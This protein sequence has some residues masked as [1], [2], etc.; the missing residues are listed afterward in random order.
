M[1]D[2]D[3][4]PCPPDIDAEN[5]PEAAVEFL[6]SQ[7]PAEF[8]N[9][10]CWFQW[11]SSAGVW[12]WN[13][14]RAHIFFWL[15]RPIPDDELKDWAKRIDAK[16]DKSLFNGVQ[17]HYTAAP[18]FDD[19]VADPVS[20]RSG[21]LKKEEQSVALRLLP[22][23]EKKSHSGTR[24]PFAEAVGFENWLVRIGDHEGGEGFHAPIRGAIASYVSTHG[25]VADRDALKEHL[26]D[27]ISNAENHHRDEATIEHYMSDAYLDASIDGAIEKFG[28][29]KRGRLVEGIPPHFKTS[30][31]TPKIAEALI[32]KHIWSWWDREVNWGDYLPSE[33]TPADQR[34]AIK[35]W[36]LGILPVPYVNSLLLIGSAGIGKST[37]AIQA[38]KTMRQ[39]D[40][41][42]VIWYLTPT[43]ELAEELAAKFGDYARVIRG[44]THRDK[45]G[46]TLCKKPEAV[47]AVAGHV[48]SI[49]KAVCKS[50]TSRCEHYDYC[51]YYAQFQAR[52][53]VYF[54][55]YEYAFQ[56]R[57]P[58]IFPPDMLIID[59]N[60]LPNFVKQLPPFTPEEFEKSA[61]RWAPL[62][63]FIVAA[64]EDHKS[65]KITLKEDRPFWTERRLRRLSKRLEDSQALQINPDMRMT[66]IKRVIG[67]NKRL[68][69]ANVVFRCL[70]A[71]M[72]LARDDVYSLVLQKDKPVKIVIDG[73]EY[74][75]FE[76][77][78]FVQYRRQ[79]KIKKETPTLIL[80][81]TGNF[82]LL[83]PNFSRIATERVE[84]TRNAIVVQTYGFRASKT[85]LVGEGEDAVRHQ[86][87]IEHFLNSF[88]KSVRGL[89]V[90]H[91][92]V[93]SDIGLPAGWQSVHLGNLRG[94]DKY[95]ECNVIV[96]VARLQPTTDAIERMAMGLFSDVDQ[97]LTNLGQEYSEEER[98]Y[99]M[100]DGSKYGVRVRCHP[101]PFVQALLEQSREMEIVQAIDRIRLRWTDEKKL[102]IVLTEIPVDV[103]VDVLIPYKDLIA[104]GSRIDRAA[105]E[106][107]GVLPTAPKF[108][109]ARFPGLWSTPK[110]ARRDLQNGS[111]RIVNLRCPTF[112]KYIYRKWGTLI[113]GFL[114]I[115]NQH[116][117][118]RQ[119]QRG[120]MSLCH[121]TLEPEETKAWLEEEFGPLSEFE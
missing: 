10:T 50:E 41:C 91:K 43:I 112:Y 2:F 67:K 51:P 26:R 7:L 106:L 13:N 87:Q 74:Q 71:E 69:V 9:T 86:N 81:A 54:M 99:R 47:E 80:D 53:H 45:D 98:G 20:Q 72:P 116:R 118:R 48:Q 107:G 79:T 75:T 90:S 16:I 102:V 60:V 52:S 55:S 68:N 31:V 49:Q 27:R 22:K 111:G 92:G 120:S 64:L 25:G 19:G 117:Y 17:V 29:Q 46:D 6:I 28:G 113:P 56:P 63:R 97:T 110:A 108:L 104:G 61:G 30:E 23:P 100:R 24:K 4:T 11:S 37:A 77:V 34:E 96:I 58:R 57:N 14:L 59:E 62:A 66:Q 114:A 42:L 76:D 115:S 103:T 93:M 15:D 105:M 1:F 109:S 70:A 32:G 121:S 82:D 95:K 35:N 84:A 39:A 38:M 65:P 21:L 12:G 94:I 89:L 44:R 101:D 8:Q 73:S 83:E 18:F 85:A 3:D 119:S 88:D 40:P 33:W 78:L 5:D 36:E